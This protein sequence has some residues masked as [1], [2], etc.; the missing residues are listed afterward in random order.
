MRSVNQAKNLPFSSGDG[1][2]C[3]KWGGDWCQT[4]GLQSDARADEMWSSNTLRKWDCLWLDGIS[5]SP[6]WH[7]PRRQSQRRQ[8]QRRHSQRW[9]S[10]WVQAQ[11]WNWHHTCTGAESQSQHDYNWCELKRNLFK[12]FFSFTPN[13]NNSS[14]L[15][16]TFILDIWFFCGN[17]ATPVFTERKASEFWLANESID[18]FIANRIQSNTIRQSCRR[19]SGKLVYNK[20]WMRQV[21]VSFVFVRCAVRQ[22]WSV[23]N[24]TQN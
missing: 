16:L 1:N 5:W 19:T 2:W 10:P 6:W 4:G 24:A 23:R 22:R 12:Y 8:S 15:I 3:C 20:Q 17:L 9:Q 7:R 18:A 21:Y 13:K 11:S 14:E